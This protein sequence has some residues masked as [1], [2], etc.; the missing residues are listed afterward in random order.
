GGHSSAVPGEFHC[1]MIE[2]TRSDPGSDRAFYLCREVG[3]ARLNADAPAVAT[4]GFAS[5]LL[6]S[7]PAVTE[8]LLDLEVKAPPRGLVNVGWNGARCPELIKDRARLQLADPLAE[9]RGEVGIFC[10]GSY[11]T[12][13]TARLMP[14]E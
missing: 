4:L 1:Q 9:D 14:T 3:Q 13:S 10:N 12:V 7:P 2:L 5:W 6:P 11:I 8:Q